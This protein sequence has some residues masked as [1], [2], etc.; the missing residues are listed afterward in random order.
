MADV[1]DSQSAALPE[2]A[3]VICR[4]DSKAPTPH[5]LL[6]R[7]AV[8]ADAAAIVELIAAVWSEYP[9]KT[10]NAALDMPELLAPASAYAARQGMFWI[11]EDRDGIAGTIAM[12]PGAD[13]H[14]VELQKLYVRASARRVGLGTDLTELVEREA[15]RRGSN[16]IE[17]WSD[18]KLLDAHRLYT[19]LGYRRGPTLRSYSDTSS[20]VRC[21][22]R[23]VLEQ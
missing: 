7:A 4:H 22:Y 17:L 2:S 19:R 11:V 10:L 13:V 21:Y 12:V 6:V 18:V 15:R 5:S 14:T 23:K 16:A 1:I 3:L 20:T 9:N 8:D